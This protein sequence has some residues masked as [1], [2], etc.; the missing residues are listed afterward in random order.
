V[1]KE[2]ISVLTKSKASSFLALLTNPVSRASWLIISTEK[3]FS[4]DYCN[5]LCMPFDERFLVDFK[6]VSHLKKLLLKIK[7]NRRQNE[8][9]CSF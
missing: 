6:I 2:N 3:F 7:K 1:Q 9:T 4:I 5:W 8:K